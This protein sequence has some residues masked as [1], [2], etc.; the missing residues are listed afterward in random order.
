MAVPDLWYFKDTNDDGV[1]DVR[2]K[3]F[4]G[5]GFR[6]D[7]GTANNLYWGLDS[8]I[9][10][11]GSN[12]GGT[13]QSLK[14]KEAKPVSIRGRDFRFHPRTREF[15][16]LSGSEQFGNAMDNWGNRFLSQNSKPAVHVVLP[17]RYLERNP[18]LPVST[19]KTDIWKG[20]TIYR[21]S[22]IEAWRLARTKLRLADDRKYS[23]PSVAHDVFSGCSGVNIYRGSVYPE[24][25]QGNLFVGDVQGNLIHRRILQPA[26]VTFTSERV[27]KETE[28]LR[29]SDNWFRPANL[30]NAPDGTF[31]I[32]DMY[33][34]TIET[35]D[36][37]TPEI[38]AMVDF[39][40]G[41][42]HGRIYRLAPKGFQ[43]PPPPALGN[44]TSEE[45]VELLKN[46]NGWW[47]DTAGRLLFERGDPSVLS[48]LRV[49]LKTSDSSLARLHAL[50]AISGLGGL[51][52][53]DLAG[54][55]SDRAP[56]IR[57][58]GLLLC[59]SEFSG[60]KE[61]L[62]SLAGDSNPRVRYQAAFTLGDFEG[63]DVAGALAEIAV[64]DEGDPWVR[65]AV[66]SAHPRLAFPV[67]KR[68]QRASHKSSLFTP[69]VA[70]IGAR[71]DREE[72]V[73]LLA[74]LKTLGP[75]FPVSGVISSLGESLK[76]SGASLGQ[77]PEAKA[78]SAKLAGR[79]KIILTNKDAK[80]PAK[81]AAVKMLGNASWNDASGHLYRLLDPSQAPEVQLAALKTLSSFAR[82]ESGDVLINSLPKLSP[83][84]RTEVIE[85]LLGR[86]AWIGP[87]LDAV[88]KQK[89]AAGQIPLAHRERLL[90]HDNPTL[91]KAAAGLF[92]A[93]ANPRAQVVETYQAALKLTGDL[94]R[95][96]EIFRQ[97]CMACHKLGEDG[98]EV[99]PNLTTV[100][101]RSPE[102][103][104]IQILDPNREVLANFTQYFVTL[105]EGRTSTGQIVSES[106]SS[107]TLRRAEGVEETILRQN[108]K[109]IMG[110]GKSLMPEGLEGAID[111][112]AMSDLISFL[113]S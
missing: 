111:L 12:S 40:S 5:F 101:S 57:E 82:S 2:E 43:P 92:S 107:L 15:Q 60:L 97:N 26:G 31:H 73:S 58:H 77:Y 100:K 1:A 64:R 85:V 11:A 91:K 104:L 106:P 35:P 109:S 7:E 112:Q 94:G 23:A 68:I 56:E 34:E 28:F 6:N 90:K 59:R 49:L 51:E 46:P 54:A 8:W 32:V 102:A 70:I 80:V 67:F 63:D 69:L 17:S 84:T 66:L 71:N 75:N 86:K 83:A 38:L 93:K 44:A 9:Y 52:E 25:F 30:V 87:L 78:L 50:Y 37:M 53:S 16:A 99:G 89:V 24:E 61:V 29:S 3:I 96:R 39:R 113:R 55:L 88:K 33:R 4:T 79:A 14:N 45:L 36:S 20:N 72:V 47:R 98:H 103:I 81:M 65:T 48:E 18:Y 22:E 105:S 27:E 13:I 42:E 19:T 74:F 10:G 41:R 95:G 108:I 62:V 21:A 76:K 110:S